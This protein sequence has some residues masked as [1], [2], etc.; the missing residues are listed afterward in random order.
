[1]KYAIGKKIVIGLSAFALVSSVQTSASAE[2][3]DQ[4]AVSATATIEEPMTFFA[5]NAVGPY[6]AIDWMTQLNAWGTPN[7]NEIASLI[8]TY[9]TTIAVSEIRI[10]QMLSKGE[11]S[12]VEVSLDGDSWKTVYA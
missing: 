2:V 7:G 4:W 10:G 8:T 6:N 5:G 3:F 9:A 11:V 1:M 12:K